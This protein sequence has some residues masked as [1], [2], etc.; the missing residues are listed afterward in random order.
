M[1]V[2]HV[3]TSYPAHPDDPSGHFVR[4]DALGDARAGHDVHVLAPLPYAGDL[5]ISAHAL[6]GRALFAWPGA[7]ARGRERPTRWLAAPR[8]M[9]RG[10]RALREVAPDVVVSHWALPSAWPIAAARGPAV[11]RIVSHGGDVRLLL[12]LPSPL[13]VA[14]V[15]RLLDGLAEWRFVARALEDALREA[16]PPSTREALERVSLVRP[17]VVDV[18]EA[19]PARGEGHLVVVGRLVRSKRVDVAIDA[20]RRAQVPLVVVGDGPDE[21]ALRRRA[22]G[23]DVTFAGRVGRRD[24]LAWVRGARALLHPSELDAAPTAVL[25]AR[26]LGVRVLAAD[27]GD[28]G[29][30]ASRD[31]GI[32]IVPRDA[33]LI[34]DAIGA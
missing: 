24:A 27:V 18:S 21:A 32:S 8:V 11:R 6:G 15:R 19:P 10:A 23:A 3:A 16:L 12:G 31:P 29:A 14:L 2:A 25:E 26:A 28:V 20:A 17:P 4:A 1:R 7:V 30:W 33:R 22:E 9:A 13:R 34:A 5:G